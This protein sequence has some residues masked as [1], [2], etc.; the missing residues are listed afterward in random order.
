MPVAFAYV[1]RPSFDQAFLATATPEQHAL[2]QRHGAYLEQLHAL[3]VVRFAGRCV[4]G[5]FALVVI[6]VEDEAAA[7]RVV[8]E[9]PSVAAGCMRPTCTR[10][11]SSWNARSGA[12]ARRCASR[13]ATDGDRGVGRPTAGAVP[14]QRD[15]AP[16]GR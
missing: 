11:P 1:L 9:D 6:D 12:P 4:D 14:A 13:G 7:R 15:G 3:G 2:F 8:E 5:P 10:S 16:A